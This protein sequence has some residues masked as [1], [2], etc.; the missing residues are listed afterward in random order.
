M[1]V[2]ALRGAMFALLLAV[3]VAVPGPSQAAP[4]LL[5]TFKNET[6]HLMTD[7]YIGFVGGA[8]LDATN[9][10]TGAPLA[11]SAFNSENWYTLD[12]LPDGIFLSHFSGR[13]YVG[14]G[15]PW[16][17]V[18]AGYE[19]SPSTPSDPNYF[20]RYDKVEITYNGNPADVANT[21]SIDHFSIP[22]A[23]HVYQ[24]GIAGKLIGRVTASTTDVIAAALGDATP[25]RDAAVVRTPTPAADFV[26]V[27]GPTTY[28]PPPGLPASPYDDFDS[29]LTHLRDIYAPAHGN[30][31]ALVEGSFAGVG[32]NPTTP[33]TMRQT[34]DFGAFIDDQ[35]N[36]TLTGSGAI[37]GQHTLFLKYA[38][39]VVPSGIYGANPLFSLDGSAPTNPLNDVYGWLIGDLLAGLNIGAVGSTVPAGN[40]VIGQLRSQEWFKLTSLFSALQ[41]DHK[42]FYNRWAAALAPVSQAYGFAY[43]DR[44]AHVVVPLNPAVVDTLQIVFRGARS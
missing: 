3:L 39:L 42:N 41:P 5:L 44:F 33:G 21:T 35:K 17:F 32:P 36:I 40:T 20:K 16:H 4:P 38:D 13:L 37:V 19:P 14:Y 29:Y 34:Y 12:K 9:V 31:L 24:G 7:V 27:I 6:D 11:L 15:E 43:S 28:P 22:V 1:K 18:R 25:R 26:R 8:L 2:S 10:A 23:L 30:I